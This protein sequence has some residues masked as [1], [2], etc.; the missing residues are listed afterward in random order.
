MKYGFLMRLET[1]QNVAFALIQPI[2]DTGGIEAVNEYYRTLDSITA[3]DIRAA[4]RAVLDDRGLTK[5][6]LLQAERGS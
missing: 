2:V 4:A 3:E 6:T 5:V 1:A